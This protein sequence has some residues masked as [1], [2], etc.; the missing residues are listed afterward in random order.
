MSLF[1]DGAAG[2]TQLNSAPQVPVQEISNWVIKAALSF[3]T[4]ALHGSFSQLTALA[5]LCDF[6]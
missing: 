2:C 4:Q 1:F 5:C 6:R 3:H